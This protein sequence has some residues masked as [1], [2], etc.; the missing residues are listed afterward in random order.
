METLIKNQHKNIL[1]SPLIWVIFLTLI[2]ACVDDLPEVRKKPVKVDFKDV[3][4][5]DQ[6]KKAKAKRSVMRIAVGAMISPESTYKYYLDLLEL[7]GERMGYGV[8][9]VQRKTYAQ[10][11]EIIEQRKLDLA[12]VCAGPYVMGKEDFGMEIIAVPV[13]YGEK[14]YYSYFI[15]HKNSTI[16]SFDQLRGK[17]FA[18]TDP[19]SNTGCLVPTYFLAKHKETPESFFKK[20]FF[21]Y[22]HD[23]SIEAVAE[24][25][26]DGAAVD[27]LIWEFMNTENPEL[28]A[29]TRIVEKSPPY[30]IHPIVVHPLMEQQKKD[31]LRTLFLTLH[32]DPKGGKILRKLQIDRFEPGNDADYNTVR[33]MQRELDSQKG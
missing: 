17:T 9:F 27:S 2:P 1:I 22:S 5:Q 13:V 31:K 16:L 8:E 18:F 15:V 26:A 11:N 30:G 7:I 24:G 4:K 6:Q 14:F 25:L 29:R 32:K 10:V 23:N 20:T 21:T 19:H 12:F 28:T 3:V 33:E